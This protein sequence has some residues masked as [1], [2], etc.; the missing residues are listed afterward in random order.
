[1]HK[2]SYERAVIIG[3]SIAGLVCARVL[4]EHFGEVIVLERDPRPDGPEPRKGAPQMRH[5]HAV[6]EV[7]TRTLR[8]LFPGIIEDML[9]AGALGMDASADTAI[10]HYGHWKPRFESGIEGLTCTRPFVEHHVRRRV[11]ALP[12]VEIRYET[13]AEELTATGGNRRI[14]GVRTTGPRGEELLSADLVL[15]SAGR[16]TR[17]PRWLS[18]F[19]YERPEEE[20]VGIDLAY[21]SRLYEYSAPRRS[22]AT[23]MAVWPRIP[24]HRGGFRF[25][26]EGGRML[27][28]LTG[29]FGDHPPVDEEGFVRFARSLPVP[30]IA[31]SIEEGRPIAPPVK[32]KIPSSRW[33]HY[34]RMKRFP[35]G[36][37]P[38]GDSV[39]ALNPVYGQGMTVAILCARALRDGL[40]D[41]ARNGGSL[42]DLAPAFLK[43]QAG[44]VRTA[45]L[46][47]ATMDLRYPQAEGKRPPAFGALQWA[48][49]QLIDV[50]SFDRGACQVFLEVLHQRRGMEALAHPAL[51]LPLL[52]HGARTMLARRPPIE[53]ARHPAVAP[54]RPARANARGETHS[55]IPRPDNP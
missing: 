53:P 54:A 26:V 19:G 6:M 27:V 8:A 39:C 23:A 13:T 15:D 52:S 2:R 49:G 25:D 46:L 35:E 29:Y 30:N 48:F 34:E 33:L 43:T 3:G 9:D 36:L 41:L 12:G 42:A 44:L 16:G 51:L 38:L 17:V 37:L 7:A 50:T 28:S 14:T 45:W 21:T 10:Y 11:E 55:P 4:S 32:H 47:S 5:V 24:D 20:T 31:D 22:D 1:M 40:A 18:S